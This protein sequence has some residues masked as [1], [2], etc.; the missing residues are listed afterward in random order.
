MAKLACC[1]VEPDCDRPVAGW[2][3]CCFKPV[4][5]YHSDLG[6]N[7]CLVCVPVDADEYMA[8]LY[9][10]LEEDELAER[11]ERLAMD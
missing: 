8:W 2:C 11:A 3:P 1:R 6:S 10:S 9:K 7:L 5:E 4:C